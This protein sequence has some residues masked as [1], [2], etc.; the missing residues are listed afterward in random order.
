MASTDAAVS[1]T[2]WALIIGG[3]APIFDSTIVAIALRDLAADLHAT[4]GTIQWVSTAYLLA[5]AVAVPVVGWAQQRFGGKRLWLVALTVFLAGSVLCACA[6]NAYSLIAFRVVQGLGGGLMM[7]LMQ[8]LVVQAAGGRSLGR[9][10]AMIGL[11]ISLGPILG[12]VLG[13]VILHSL[14]WPWLFLVNVPLCLAG[15]IAAALMLPADPITTTRPRLDLTGLALLAPALGATLLGLS[16]VA[17][18]GGFA[19]TDV[20]VPLLAGVALLA[21]FTGHALRRRDRALIDLR[22]LAERPLAASTTVL[23]FAGAV[24]YGAMLLLPLFLQEERGLSVLGAALFLIPQGAG[25]LVLRTQAGKLTDRIGARWVAAAGFVVVTLGT[26]P[27]AFAGPHT[28]TIW[29]AVVLFVRGLGLGAVLI[30]VM[31]VAY[32]DLDHARIPQASMITRISQQVG[33]S[34]GTAAMAVVLQAGHGFRAAFWVA[35]ALAVLAIALSFLLP[36]PVRETA[37]RQR[38]ASPRSFKVNR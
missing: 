17:H 30:P 31:T 10:V 20:L 26:V 18:G 19:R 3:L 29:L 32:L 22:L 24:L 15:L 5:L 13:G 25:S 28:S 14:S 8:S 11:P 21:T 12:P 36:A 34:L 2:A 9:V 16:N 35:S 33:G 7:P 4:V 6:W 23:G 27:F 38:T 37:E 1:R